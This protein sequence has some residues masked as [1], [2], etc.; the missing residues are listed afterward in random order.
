MKKQ[1]IFHDNFKVNATLRHF[2]SLK[3]NE[4]YAKTIVSIS[5]KK[6]KMKHH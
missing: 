3:V 5:K 1:K 4:K 2:F 6:K